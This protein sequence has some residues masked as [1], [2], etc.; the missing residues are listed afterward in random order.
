MKAY[1]AVCS[2]ETCDANT[3]HKSGRCKA[4]RT[5][6]CKKCGREYALL[7][8]RRKIDLCAFCASRQKVITKFQDLMHT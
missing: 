8:R 4:C 1:Q 6:K 5:K 3:N 7:E 2:I